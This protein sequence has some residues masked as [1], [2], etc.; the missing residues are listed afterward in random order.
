[1]ATPPVFSFIF[2]VSLE[3]PAFRFRG[4]FKMGSR[5]SL[6]TIYGVYASAGLQLAAAV[7][8]GLM[9]GSYFDEKL[10]SS[11]WCALA[12]TLLGSV[13]GFMNFVRIIKWQQKRLGE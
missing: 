6:Y 3:N 9:A 4:G 12:G 8:V 7:V 11:P 5:G 2:L 1:M 13:G 10:G